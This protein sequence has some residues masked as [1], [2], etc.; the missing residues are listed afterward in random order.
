[1]VLGVFGIELE[2]WPNYVIAASLLTLMSG[3]ILFG[4]D[5]LRKRLLPRW[6]AMP[7][8]VGLPTILL[9][10]PSSLIDTST[11][12]HFELTLI[13]TFLR[14]GLTGVGWVLLGIVLPDS[15]QEHEPVR[16]V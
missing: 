16:V 12:H 10:V 6:N 14:F 8:L 11:P 2:P 1:M 7:L 5:A 9:I 15:Q 4:I 3:H 13:T